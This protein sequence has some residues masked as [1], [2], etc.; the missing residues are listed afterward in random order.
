MIQESL[1]MQFWDRDSFVDGPIRSILYM[2]E[3]EY[4]FRI[5]EFVRLLSALCKGI[6]PAECVYVASFFFCCFCMLTAQ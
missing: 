3:R 2:L 5:V 6:W 1:S 4:P